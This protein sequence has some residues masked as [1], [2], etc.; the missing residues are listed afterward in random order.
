MVEIEGEND[1]AVAQRRVTDFLTAHPDAETV[2]YTHLDVYKR[3]IAMNHTSFGGEPLRCFPERR[4]M[5][6]NLL[7]VHAINHP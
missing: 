1:A 6:I 7:F 3:Q 4:G 2:S 5:N